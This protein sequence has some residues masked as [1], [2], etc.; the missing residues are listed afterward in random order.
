[1]TITPIQALFFMNSEMVYETAGAWARRLM[2]S[3]PNEQ[4]RLEAA[5]RTALGRMPTKEEIARAS[6]Y[7]AAARKELQSSGTDANELPA[8]ALASYLRALLAGNEFSF[9]D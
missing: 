3:Q 4:R 6:Q 8:A 5:Y 2:E 9:V 1:M 7:V